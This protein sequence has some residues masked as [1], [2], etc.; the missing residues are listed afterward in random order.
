MPRQTFS[1][2]VASVCPARHGSPSEKIVLA[3][4]IVFFSGMCFLTISLNNAIQLVKDCCYLDCPSEHPGWTKEPEDEWDSKVIC[5]HAQGVVSG[6]A[7]K[8]F[9]EV[10]RLH[11]LQSQVVGQADGSCHGCFA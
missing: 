11:P 3:R 1:L 6:P 8:N 9:G 5:S 10:G 4:S 2:S 7:V